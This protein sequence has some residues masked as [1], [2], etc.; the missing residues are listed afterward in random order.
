MLKFIIAVLAFA[1]LVSLFSSAFFLLKDKGNTV[2]AFYTLRV[3]VTLA[4]MLLLTIGYGLFTG[5]LGLNSP[6]G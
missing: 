1:M 4:V 3:R 5:Q 2:R 6:W